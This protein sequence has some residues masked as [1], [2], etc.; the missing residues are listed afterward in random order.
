M[1][2]MRIRLGTAI[3]GS[4]VLVMPISYQRQA[5]GG[6]GYH[7]ARCET[8][9]PL[10]DTNFPFRPA[11]FRCRWPLS[12]V[13]VNCN[14]ETVSTDYDTS[15][16]LYF[17][18]LTVEDVLEVV[19]AERAAGPVAGVIAQL[20]GQ[21]PLRLA[22]ALADA[23]VPLVGTPP[24]AIHQAE[25][26]GEF[27]R[28][29]GAAGLPAPPHGTALSFQQAR[30]VAE[31]IGYPVL[32][33][34]SYV[35]GGRGMEIVHTEAGLLDYVTQ[36]AEISPEH[37]VL[38]DR[39]L[40]DAT[41]LDVDALYDGTEL[42]L[43]GVMEHIEQAGIHSGDSACVLPP[44]TVDPAR[45]RR[46]RDS[47][48]AIAAGVGVRGLLNVQFALS[49]DVLYVLEANPRAPRTVPFVSKATAVPLA[50]AAARIA[51]GASIAQL[52]RE[53]LLPAA[54]DGGTLPAG[55]PVA[56]K[57][58]VLPWSRFRTVEGVGID[59]LLGPEMRSTGEVMGIDTTFG[60]AFAK[61][62]AAAGGALPTKGR[63]FVSVTD[64]DKPAVVFAVRALVN[65]GFEILATEGTAAALRRAGVAAAVVGR[66]GEA[67]PTVL[68]LLGTGEIDLVVNTTHGRV[69]AAGGFAVR[70]AAVA[71]GVPFL[72]TIQAL[73]AA[74]AGIETLL[75]DRTGVCSLQEHSRRLLAAGQ[76]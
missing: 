11:L 18:P 61:S 23:G 17:E 16:R 53:G 56:V 34:P 69:G 65:L 60:A 57:E 58:A 72:T 24:A 62:Q 5:P 4:P 29:L 22:Q 40:D 13:L 64:R 12:T 73:S 52:R 48:E 31:R 68:G 3:T 30:A 74:V 28:L 54:G 66:P 33:R 45:L 9:L 7:R 38:V 49:G 75:R 37:P 14:P 43:G 25:D 6:A 71:H 41:E 55:A 35:L 2:R 32:V 36:A 47:T 1:F 8:R 27:G 15:D 63:A 70:A 39:F 46:L 19:D 20:G 10:V 26:R 76:P 59:V 50:K 67:G 21:T 44:I 42:Y 51:L